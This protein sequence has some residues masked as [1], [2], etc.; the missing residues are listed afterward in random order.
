MFKGTE[1]IS[2]EEK[3]MGL[4]E[5]DY[6]LWEIPDNFDEQDMTEEQLAEECEPPKVFWERDIDNIDDSHTK[7]LAIERAEDLVAQEADLDQAL[8]SG[9]ITEDYYMSQYENRLRLRKID[10]A[11][12]C[13]IESGRL[14][15][16]DLGDPSKGYDIP[17]L[18]REEVEEKKKEL[19]RSR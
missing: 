7:L 15:Y 4:T 14:T 12:K 16:T 13:A 5:E 2:K 19:G 10:A 1:T 9:E 6:G 8:E 17:E 18:A 3:H 11:S